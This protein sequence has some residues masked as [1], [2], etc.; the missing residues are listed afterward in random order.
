MWKRLAAATA[1]GLFAT[2]AMFSSAGASSPTSLAS[3]TGAQIDS[4][5]LAQMKAE[6]SYTV[7]AVSS[8]S[9]FNASSVTSS[10]L[11]SGIRHDDVNGQRGERLFLHGVAY[12]RFSA[13]LGKIY[14][15]K[16]VPTLANRWISLTRGHAYYSAFS[17]AMIEPTL[18]PLL[19]LHGTLSV[20]APLTFDARSVVA[21]NG[22]NTVSSGTTSL[23]ET[24]F[25]ANTPPFVPVALVL[26][27]HQSGSSKTIEEMTFKNWGLPVTVPA[28]SHSTPSSQLKFP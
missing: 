20:S 7:V 1:M 11:T 16:S 6:G 4:L 8:D 23:T 25:V 28:P 18:A 13:G 12:A 21:I 9:D 3:L 27:R 22:D 17:S 19:V 24:L 26:T 14:F 15:N 10:T 5:A 2:F